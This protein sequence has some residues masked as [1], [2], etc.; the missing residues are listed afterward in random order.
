MNDCMCDAL[1]DIIHDA[2]EEAF[3]SEDGELRDICEC[4][5]MSIEFTDIGLAVRIGDQLYGVVIERV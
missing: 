5:S 2:I 4:D 3:I 1:R